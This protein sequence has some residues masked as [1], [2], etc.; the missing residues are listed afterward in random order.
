MKL[1]CL[2]AGL[3]IGALIAFGIYYFKR[4]TATLTHDYNQTIAEYDLR[5]DSLLTALNEVEVQIDTVEVYLTKIVEKKVVVVQEIQMLPA[6]GHVVYW[7]SLTGNHKPS[8]LI[9]DST[10]VVTPM[11]RI[12]HA[13]EVMAV[14]DLLEQ[15]VELL[16]DK[17][18]LQEQKIETLVKINKESNEIIYFQNLEISRMDDKVEKI[19]E[20][21]KWLAGGV[22]A[23]ILMVF[24][25]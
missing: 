2:F 13:L 21:N 20:L 3:I 15:E 16:C 10:L 14:K 23:L 8:K 6:I 5:V 17:T 7:D 25:K 18:E 19:S 24:I 11:P 4:H 12:V 1:K 22:G 9:A